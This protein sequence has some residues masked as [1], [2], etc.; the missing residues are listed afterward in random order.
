MKLWVLLLLN[1]CNATPEEEG[2]F[3]CLSSSGPDS[4]LQSHSCYCFL[5]KIVLILVRHEVLSV[6]C[7]LA[8][9]RFLATIL[10]ISLNKKE[11]SGWQMPTRGA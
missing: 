3:F 8:L 6:S 1:R 9:F 4:T 11:A 7:A 2:C 5:V 10:L